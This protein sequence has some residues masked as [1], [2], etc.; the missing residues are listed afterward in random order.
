MSHYLPSE[1][2]GYST[3]F[4][5]APPSGQS[6]YRLLKPEYSSRVDIKKPVYDR[7]N[8]APTVFRPH[9][10]RSFRDPNNSFEP[11]RIDPAGQNFFGYWETQLMV[12]WNI[13]NPATT[14][15]CQP[16]PNSGQVWD[17]RQSPLSIV[18]RAVEQA[19]RLGQ[20]KQG[21][22]DS[23]RGGFNILQYP[24]LNMQWS[25]A[26]TGGDGKSALLT[27]P[28]TIFALQGSVLMLGGEKRLGHPDGV[29]GWGAN[30]TCVMLFT[31][32]LG[33]IMTELLN[34][35]NPGYRG[36]PGN[37]E[38]RYVN[39][40]P[41]SLETG[42]FFVI[43]PKGHR[44]DQ[45]MQSMATSHASFD[46]MVT[47]A[48]QSQGGRGGRDEIGFDMHMEKSCSLF[49][50]PI[51]AS[52]A[53]REMVRDKWIHWHEMLH[54]PSAEEQ[55][56]I[57][58]SVLP[59]SMLAYAFC[60][61][62]ARFLTADIQERARVEL[63]SSSIGTAPYG[64]TG[65]ASA[66]PAP[67]AGSP[68]GSPP[69]SVLP[70]HGYGTAPAS[71]YSQ[72]A[73]TPP[74]PPMPPAAPYGGA[75]PYGQPAAAYGQAPPPPPYAASPSPA[76][77][78]G[79]TSWSSAPPGHGGHPPTPQAPVGHGSSDPNLVPFPPQE[80]SYGSGSGW[81]ASTD[82]GRIDASIS[83]PQGGLDAML[84]Q[85]AA[86]VQQGLDA[87]P[88]GAIPTAS[89]PVTTPANLAEDPAALA[90]MLQSLGK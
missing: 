65:F 61:E 21:W 90:G 22:S 29:F 14:F 15:I 50:P 82:A 26:T 70:A 31:Y 13:G 28:Q 11:Y 89:A 16:A 5:T 75:A 44:P 64:A 3:A 30:N 4:A 42:R 25:G 23:V 81:G 7:R 59:A 69:S 55:A 43:Y 74:P 37:F 39:G 46:Q 34:Q 54:Y 77:A 1:P 24:Q 52:L 6:Q 85:G 2:P 79:Q 38:A 40:D 83:P 18:H 57:L 73:P 47:Q 86:L 49:G 17:P 53:N 35:E 67:P 88:L 87:P 9:P 66:S 84:A 78:Y 27:K 58:A 20:G 80:A 12:A 62:N 36:D 19:V 33:K 71:P 76:D 51:G 45:Q 63:G 60:G 41:V 8:G 32:G 72:A 10:C 68:Y 48:P 56:A